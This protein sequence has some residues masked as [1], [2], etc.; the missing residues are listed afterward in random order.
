MYHVTAGLTKSF[1]VGRVF[2]TLLDEQTILGLAIGATH[3]GLLPIPEIQYLAYLMNAIDQLRGEAG[4]MQFF[5][6]GEQIEASTGPVKE[7][8]RP[9][10]WFIRYAVAV[11][12]EEEKNDVIRVTLRILHLMPHPIRCVASTHQDADA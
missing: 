9:R 3:A 2:N 1:G 4:S 6:N 10:R 5:S 11:S 7:E 12:R 8:Y